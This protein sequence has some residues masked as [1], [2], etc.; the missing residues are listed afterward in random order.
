MQKINKK[1]LKKHKRRRCRKVGVLIKK[2]NVTKCNG[3]RLREL[4]MKNN[5]KHAT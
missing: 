3:N 4:I 2:E 1:I 5:M